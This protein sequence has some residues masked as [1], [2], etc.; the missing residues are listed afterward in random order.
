VLSQ[1]TGLH[2]GEFDGAAISIQSNIGIPEIF[3]ETVWDIAEL[4]ASVPSFLGVPADKERYKFLWSSDAL[5][6]RITTSN[7]WSLIES[8]RRHIE[9]ERGFDISAE[10]RLALQRT[11]LVIEEKARELSG[12]VQLSHSGYYGHPEMLEAMAA[13]LVH[14]RYPTR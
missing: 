13:F 11:C 8:H 3:D 12:A 5:A 9:R 1:A 7:T 10:E 14:G 4:A 2:P 6:A